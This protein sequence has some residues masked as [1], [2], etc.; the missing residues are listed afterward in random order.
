M[1]HATRGR[2]HND[3]D[4]PLL[5]GEEKELERVFSRLCNFAAKGKLLKKHSVV[6]Q[7]LAKIRSHKQRPET[8]KVLDSEGG[9]M[10]DEQI[11][12]EHSN[13]KRHDASIS[14]ELQGVNARSKL[15]HLAD[16]NAALR[17][18]G[19]K[20]KKA[21]YVCALVPITLRCRYI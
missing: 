11:D 5:A 19:V 12:T 13:L 16:M 10:T 9:M 14:N 4:G 15:I 1:P 2:G 17:N 18:L 21:R 8:M 3:K 6:L 20:K 7:R